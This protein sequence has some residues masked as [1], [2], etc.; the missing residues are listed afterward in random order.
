M[1]VLQRVLSGV[2][3]RSVGS[4]RASGFGGSGVSRQRSRSISTPAT[5]HSKISNTILY[6]Y[7]NIAVSRLRPVLGSGGAEL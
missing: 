6:S 3:E 2:L 7:D 1:R 4:F 5:L